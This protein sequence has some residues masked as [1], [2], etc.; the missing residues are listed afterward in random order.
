MVTDNKGRIWDEAFDSA[1]QWIRPELVGK[2]HSLSVSVELIV[3]LL[4]L[5]GLVTDPHSGLVAALFSPKI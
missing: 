2:H 1:Y 4:Q 3:V 5:V